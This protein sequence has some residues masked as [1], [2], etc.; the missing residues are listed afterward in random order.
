MQRAGGPRDTYNVAVMTSAREAVPRDAAKRHARLCEEIERHNRLYFLEATPEITDQQFDALM[1]E[2]LDVEK[3][4]PS[5]VTPESP[6]QRVGGAPLS[7][8]ETVTHTVPMLS[9]DNTYNEGELR[10][11]DDRVRRGLEGAHPAYV[12]ELK[13]DGV[14]IS[15][16]FEDGQFVRAATRGDGVQGDDVSQNVRTIRVLPIRLTGTPPGVLEVRG[17]VFMHNKELERINALREAAGEPPLANPRNTTAGTL[18]MLDS[19][20]VA[21]RRLDMVFYD[22]AVTE[23][24]SIPSHWET[25]SA[26]KSFGLP[27]SQ[28]SVRCKNIEDVLNV[29]E[30]WE[31]RRNDL[32]Y[33]IDGLVVK[34]DSAAQRRQLGS[35]SKSPRW[36]IAYKY[37]AQVARTKLNNITLQVGKTGV[38]TPVA[39]LEPVPLAGTIVKRATLHNFE[40]LER[41]DVRVGDTVEVQK[42]GEIIPQVLRF[43]P[44]LRP[45]SAKKFPLPKKCPVCGGE[46]HKDPEGVFWRCLSPSCPA[47]L[48]ERIRYFASRG[49]M[50][51]EGMGPAVIEELVDNG[52]VKDFADLYE[53]TAEQLASVLI[54]DAKGSRKQN[55][56][57]MKSVKN[58][59]AGID[60]SKQRPLDRLLHGLGIRH[61]GAHTAE[62]LAEQFGDMR[63]LMEA[64][65][66]ELEQVHEIGHVVAASI[67]DFFDTDRNRELIGRLEA[68]GVNMRAEKRQAE[69]GGTVF[70]GKTFVVTGS[71][72][73]YSRDE[74]HERIKRLGGKAASSVSKKTDYV[75]AGEEAGSKLEKA[76]ELGVRVL[77]EDEFEALAKGGA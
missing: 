3:K 14:A 37:P 74:I 21:Q 34:V 32:D 49:A 66:E 17:E 12:V 56:A 20:V 51:I 23:G 6:S 33:E 26:L 29:C 54:K 70:E 5:L 62:V 72:I 52:L 10:A 15:V 30:E 73:N 27:V 1:H 65:V 16:R 50:D 38:I 2:L 61:V 41:K 18:K 11:F 57:E 67:R 31:R 60:V 48:K 64:S 55:P 36:V 40:E 69:S 75:V 22:I 7:E 35:T 13:V 19:R 59:I 71:L 42:A 45:A 46:V 43:V 77:S 76:R 28:H 8:F 44:E 24:L 63:R 68:H 53:L 39:E 47:Q 4:Y 25:L 9:I 58:L